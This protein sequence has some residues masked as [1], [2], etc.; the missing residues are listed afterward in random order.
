[1]DLAVQVDEQGGWAVA[2][3]SGDLD[4][5][6]APRLRERLVQVVVGGQPRLVLDLQAVDFVDSTGLGVIV[7]VLK[8]TRSQG[9]DLRLVSTRSALRKIL[10]LTSLD[11]ALPLAAT[12]EEALMEDLTDRGS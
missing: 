3:V 4:L 12:V 7:G 11:Q 2:R 6:T 9:G 1:V 10:E 8:R 5:T